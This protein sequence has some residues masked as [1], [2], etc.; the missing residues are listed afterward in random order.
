MVYP[1]QNAPTMQPVATRRPNDVLCS[2]ENVV[3]VI[4]G[5]WPESESRA[6]RL[7]WRLARTRLA[8]VS[9]GLLRS[10]HS[11]ARLLLSSRIRRA[12]MATNI[13]SSAIKCL[14]LDRLAAA[15]LTRSHAQLLLADRGERVSSVKPVQR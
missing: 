2:V 1:W 4:H 12:M 11:F 8:D 7:R 13:T 10:A 14:K 5:V 9:S 15:Q 3:L 6:E